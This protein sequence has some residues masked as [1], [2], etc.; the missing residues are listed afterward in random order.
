MQVPKSAKKVFSGIIFEVYQWP[1]EMYDGSVATFEKAVRQNT[2]VIIPTVGN[3][4]MMVKQ[5]Q[6][7]TD[8]FFDLPSGRMDKKGES[9]KNAA[10]R[11]LL[12]ETGLKPK[13]IK[14]WRTYSPSG[15]LQ[16][17]IYFF[18]AQDCKKVTE[19]KL[20]PGE[21]IIPFLTTFDEFLKLTDNQR[22]FLGPL[23]IDALL[24]RIHKENYD[25]LRKSFFTPWEKPLPLPKNGPKSNW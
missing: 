2:V 20:D 3:K 13:S 9:P 15:K 16:Q 19:Q 5:K 6:P 11:E 10:L 18:V 12:E 23:M 14:L 24:A 1:Q 17:T 8:W 22:C 7:G 4:I 21:N 25:Y